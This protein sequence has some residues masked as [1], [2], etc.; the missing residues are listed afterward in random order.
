MHAQNNFRLIHQFDAS[1]YKYL[2]V[3][4]GY[5]VEWIRMENDSLVL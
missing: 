3:D 5:T 1:V 2:R 4:E